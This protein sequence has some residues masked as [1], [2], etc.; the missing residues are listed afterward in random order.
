MIVWKRVT[1]HF[2]GAPKLAIQ[3]QP[4]GKLPSGCTSATD[5]GQPTLAND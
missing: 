1:G 5:S 3:S 4:E 2:G